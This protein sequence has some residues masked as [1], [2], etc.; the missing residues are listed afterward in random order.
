MHM[1]ALLTGFRMH[2]RACPDSKKY[3]HR[4]HVRVRCSV[5]VRAREPENWTETKTGPKY[6][7]FSNFDTNGTA[8]ESAEKG[9]S[10]ASKII[11]KLVRV[12]E[13]QDVEC[14]LPGDQKWTRWQELVQYCN[15]FE[16]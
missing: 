10:H 5:H 4:S 1:K 9:L 14:T 13:L 11:A 6:I 8:Y 2:P 3:V 12:A 7:Y 15:D 16:S